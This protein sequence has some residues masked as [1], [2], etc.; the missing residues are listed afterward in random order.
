MVI[1]SKNQARF[2]DIFQLIIWKCFLLYMHN[3]LFKY[4]Y[5][6]N[7]SLRIDI[8]IKVAQLMKYSFIPLSAVLAGKIDSRDF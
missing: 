2:W 1:Y 4:A 6:L 8:F 7:Q 3:L 5:I